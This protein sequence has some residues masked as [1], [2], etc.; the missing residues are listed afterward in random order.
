MSN[1]TLRF[2]ETKF[3]EFFSSTVQKEIQLWADYI[4]LEDMRQFVEHF[5]DRFS[6]GRRTCSNR[7]NPSSDT[8]LQ[9]LSQ[10]CFS[11]YPPLQSIKVHSDILRLPPNRI[12]FVMSPSGC[13]LGI[14]VDR[15]Q[16]KCKDS[17]YPLV[18]I[19]MYQPYIPLRSEYVKSYRV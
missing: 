5:L 6:P 2:G 11:L 16:R 10:S 19:N 4:Q 1:F 18:L 13:F 15:F 3:P 14:V 12:Y 9:P 8:P 7:D 17:T